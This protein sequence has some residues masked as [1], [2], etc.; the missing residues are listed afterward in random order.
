MGLMKEAVDEA[1]E[2]FNKSVED[3][4]LFVTAITD[5]TC[6]TV[7]GRPDYL[8]SF[9]ASLSA[10]AVVHKTSL[11]TLYHTP[12]LTETVR[13]RVLSDITTRNIKFP[14]FSDIRVPIRSTFTGDA[15]TRNFTGA[16][17]LAELAVNMIISQPINWISVVEKTVETVPLETPVRLLNCGPGTGLTKGIERVFSRRNVSTLDLSKID[18]T[19]DKD[20]S[21]RESIAIVGM[22]VNMPGA[23]NNEK[24]WEVLETGINTISEIPV[25]RFKVDDY[26]SGKNP[27]RS[28]KA[29]T[30]NFIENADGF[31]NKFFKISP[32]EAKSMDPQQRIL[33]H[34]AY[35][36]LEDAGYVPYSTETWSPETF[37]CY[38]GVATHDYL[39]NL[40]N[41][42]DVYYSTGTLKAFLSGRISYAMQLSGPSVVIDTACSSSAVAFY[43]GARALINRDCNAALVGGVNIVSSPD[44]FL[45]LDR[46]HFLSPTGQ[47]KAFDVSADGYSRSEGVGMFVLKRLS[48]AVAENDNILGVIRGIEVNQSGLAHSIT[49]PH[50]PTQA[51]LFHRVLE[52]AGVDP[53]R[54]NV[55]EAHG[56]G[57]QAGDPNELESIRSAFAQNRPSNNPLHIT[58]V[59]SNIG[60]LEAASGAAG[61]AKL[62]LMLRHKT[63]PRVISLKNL[64]PRIVDLSSDNTI[65]D[66]VQTAWVPSEEGKSRMA[67][68]NNFGAAGSN[69]AMVLEEYVA[70]PVE[71]VQAG[72]PVVF[73][74][75]AKDLNALEALRKRV[76]DWVQDPK[77]ADESLLDIAYTSTARRHLYEHR[78][79]VSVSNK[80]ELVEKLGKAPASQVKDAAFSTAFVFS[81]QGSQYLG[82][83]RSLYQTTPVFRKAIDDCHS[84]LVAAGFPGVLPIITPEGESSGLTKLEEFEANQAA[85]FSLEYALAKLWLSW[86]VKPSVVVGHSLGEY[87]AL[88]VANVLTLKGALMIIANRVRFMVQKCAVDSTSMLA[89]NLPSKDIQSILDSSSDFSGITIACYNS[90]VDN[91][92]AGPI[93]QLKAFK[94][95]LDEHVHCKNVL[96][97]VPF[98]YHSSAMNPLLDDLRELA[99]RITINPPTV[100][101]ISNVFGTL[102]V[103]GDTSVFDASYFARHCSEPVQFA[104]GIQDL[105]ANGIVPAI[106]AWIEIGPHTTTLPMLKGIPEVSKSTLLLGSLRKQQEPWSTLTAALSQL[107][108]TNAPIRWRDVFAHTPASCI[109]FATY[110]FNMTKFWVSFEEDSPAPVSQ[111]VALP[112]P[113]SSDLPVT[114][115]KMLRAWSQYP[116]KENGHVAIFETPI[117][118]LAGSIRGHSV[119]GMPLCPASVYL[120]QVF[121]GLE[122]AHD[123]LS[124]PSSDKHVVLRGIEFAK[125][126]VYDEQVLRTVITNITVGADG[127]GKFFVASRVEGSVEES[128]HVHG[129]Y[130]WEAISKTSKKFHRTLPVINRHIAAV[131]KPK[132]GKTPQLF[133]TRTAYEVIFPRVVDYAKEYHTMQS[134]TVD[135]AG[136]EGFAPV[137]LPASYDRSKFV[138]HPVFTDTL[139]HVAGF[140][141][142]MHGGVNDAYICSEVGT[143]KVIPEQV[144]NTASYAVYCNN[145]WLPDQGV[146]LAEAYAVKRTEPPVL[147]A[148]LKGM[149]FRKVR[150][151]SLKKGLAHAAGKSTP[152]IRSTP[153]HSQPTQVRSPPA[154]EKSSAPATPSPTGAIGKTEAVDVQAIVV[155]IVAETCD[156]STSSMDAKTDLGDLGVDSLM[157]IEIFG[158]LESAFPSITLDAHKLSH[159]RSIAEIVGEV[160]SK[161]PLPPSPRT[162]SE[163]QSEVSSPRTLVADDILPEPT[164]LAVDSDVDIRGILAAILDVSPKDITLDTDLE[165]L[166]LDSLTSIEALAALKN[167][168]GFD[169]PG[170]FFNDYR[171]A[172]NIQS[173]L[174]TQLST[175]KSKSSPFKQQSAH[176]SITYNIAPPKAVPE[177]TSEFS[178]KISPASA[179]R[180]TKALKLDTVPL[181]LQKSTSHSLPLFLIHD[182]SGLI[183]YYNGITS[184]GRQVWG[185]NNPHFASSEP[186]SG[187]HAMASAYATYISKITTGPVILGGWSFGGVAAYETSLQLAKM[188]IKTQGILLIDSP[189]PINHVPLSDAL[190]DSVVNLDAR[191]ANSDLGRLVKAQ[192]AMNAR[193]LGKYDPRATGGTCPPLVL[194]RSSEGFNPPGVPNVP[195]WLANR[196]DPSIATAGWESL[197]SG[198]M[199]V[200]DIPGHHFTPFYPSNIKGVAERMIEACKLLEQA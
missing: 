57:T 166:G 82:M 132:N 87:A 51:N 120:E 32:R 125:P 179:T 83:G 59:K 148:H 80:E 108:T 44:M 55:V 153:S 198:P 163:P 176:D 162:S 31:D 64:N 7:S 63:I 16:E 33:L 129:E 45:G 139:L 154:V 74:I 8:A 110:P 92:L 150:L 109:S 21:Q 124:I 28:M 15:I 11:D 131:L 114:S 19:R 3:S 185:F 134:I 62:L 99:K 73:G 98:G 41:E 168:F 54:I 4:A 128:V 90:S 167:E 89:V 123:K 49:H 30:G 24:L 76:I 60:H 95:H 135:P 192:F 180:L 143:V 126:L 112:D 58:S 199:K 67:L 149:H 85:I 164:P 9:S 101:I 22:A 20:M 40:R 188:G 115:F 142:N 122:L 187:V 107:Y 69:T 172:R 121:A 78:L 39:Q 104:R 12:I 155:R 5:A 181:P 25:H 65:I 146:M 113:S 170:S 165:S 77:H 36:A 116:T 147:V 61:L 1:V 29:H 191:S 81:G 26:N 152:Q 53:H 103:P 6:I 75:S 130:K 137:K 68:L 84:I 86:G 10:T 27:K 151:N 175:S 106:D 79:A 42:I 105:V 200:L 140:V 117:S 37:G 193:M 56:T 66:T 23:P 48:D 189:S 186:W 158:K 13:D 157:S 161:A 178:V 184:L 14:A 38:V 169:L 50:A 118:Q 52:N 173:Y 127:S 18:F 71:N 2:S 177:E 17:T 72:L 94:A 197:A 93:P 194:L 171:T 156:V 102:V 47:C 195:I 144:D 119:G 34:A 182:G 190:I 138:V 43:Q 70:P 100:P 97:S 133:S 159:C 174:S 35:E 160:S 96:L 88:V 145:A 196:S 46:G 91:V 136:M 183:N 141:A 111:T